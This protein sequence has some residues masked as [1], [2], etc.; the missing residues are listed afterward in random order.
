MHRLSIIR[1]DMK[2]WHI[3][4]FALASCFSV[5]ANECDYLI[6]H[7][8]EWSKAGI[9]SLEF[10]ICENLTNKEVN[11]GKPLNIHQLEQAREKLLEPFNKEKIFDS[12]V[13]SSINRKVDCMIATGNYY[14]CHCIGKNLPWALTYG[15]YLAIVTSAEGINADAFQISQS[16]FVKLSGI[17]WSVR[18][19]CITNRK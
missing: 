19:G 13:I 15:G 12:T 8:S 3:F 11:N 10:S 1:I 17:V 2:K 18:D 14:T 9:K 6:D 4:F 5:F 16:D 7:N